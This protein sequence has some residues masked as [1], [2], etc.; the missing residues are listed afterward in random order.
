MKITQSLLSWRYFHENNIQSSLALLCLGLSVALPGPNLQAQTTP[1]ADITITG[2][3]ADDDFGWQVAPAGDV[4]GDGIPDFIIG[5]PSND[6]VGGFAGRAY[7]FYGPF[8]GNI[9]A[10]NAD[11]IISAEAFG[12]NLGFSVASAGDV[13]NDGFDDIIVGARSND[14]RGI[15][16]GRVYLFYGPLS[17]SLAATDA[18]AI[19]SGVAFDELG[20]AVAPA[21][22][23]NG[24]GFDDIL[25]GSDIAGGSFQGQVFLFNGPLFGERTA[26]SADA[27]ITGSFPN[28]SF[29]ASVA[30]AG[31]V[32]G[33][34]INDVIIGAPR[35]PLN[36]ADTGRAY[37]FFGPIA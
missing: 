23:L 17:G 1:P 3:S 22:D 16:S 14:T 21:G 37:I 19:I 29:G 4:N 30:S 25:L 6:A 13:N 31:D 33:D 27:I 35:F 7:L 34:G 36:G 2:E 10:A 28:E 9:N 15:Q 11:A 12:D 24:D 8:T 26:A 32:N 18:D 20:R 5:A